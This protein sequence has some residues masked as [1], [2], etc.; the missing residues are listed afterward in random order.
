MNAMTLP[1]RHG[2]RILGPGGLRPSTL[3]LGLGGSTHYC[4]FTSEQ[5]RNIVSSGSNPRS[6]IF[7]AGSFNHCTCALAQTVQDRLARP[8]L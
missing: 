3:P 7:K 6:P 5:R 2:I 4:I 1:S 8:L